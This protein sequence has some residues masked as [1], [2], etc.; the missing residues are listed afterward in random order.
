M[1]I[2][3]L[4]EGGAMQPGP[5]LSQ[6]LGPAGINL[7]QVISKVN[8][9]TQNFKGMK[10]PVVLDV[11]TG[12]KEFE[13]SVSSPPAS[14]LIKKELKI[15]KGSVE[16]LKLQAANASIEQIISV[17]KS[18]IE[19]MLAK[20]LKAAVKS[21]GGT[22]ASLGILIESK[23]ATEFSAHVDSGKYDKEISEQKTETSS[24]KLAKLKREF[25][26]IHKKQEAAIKEEEA[27][28]EAAKEAAAAESTEAETPAEGEAAPTE[29]TETKP[30][31]EEKK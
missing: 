28:A 31:E 16:Q 3:L 10:V 2:K 7:G 25:E 15:D 13:I 6:K 11:D 4:V 17:A 1:E 27:A 5:A 14:E 26:N 9:A 22:C 29:S 18:K 20:D 19:G 12:T 24:E 8:E 30:D 23:P 21:I